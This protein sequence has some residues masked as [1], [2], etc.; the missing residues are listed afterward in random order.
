M[1]LGELRKELAAT[2]AQLKEV[3]GRLEVCEAGGGGSGGRK[4]RAKRAT[5]GDL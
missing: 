4:G 5:E 1:L 3:Q 2:T